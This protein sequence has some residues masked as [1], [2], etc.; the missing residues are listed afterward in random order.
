[1]LHSDVLPLFPLG[2]TL[3]PGMDLPLHIF[4]ERYRRLLIDQ[5]GSDPLFGVVLIRSGREVVDQ[6]AVHEIGTAAS[7]VA[8]TPYPDGRTSIIVRGNRRFQITGHDW[9]RGYLIGTITWLEEPVGDDERCRVL[10]RRVSDLWAMLIRRLASMVSNQRDVDELIE[11]LI[12]RL[13][14]DP[15]A[16]CYDILAQMPL[17]ASTRQH[18]LELPTTETRLASLNELLTSEIRLSSAFR[19]APSLIYASNKPINPN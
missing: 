10:A 17:P 6:P 14:T 9:S 15:T 5:Q 1:M 18:Y 13:P 4:E 7:L 3:M 16:R 8:E 19:S 2:S 11:V 12:S